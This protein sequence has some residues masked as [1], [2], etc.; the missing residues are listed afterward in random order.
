MMLLALAI[1][2]SV[3]V[4]V[5][6]SAWASGP[7]LTIGTYRAEVNRICTR[8]QRETIEL[9]TIARSLAGYRGGQVPKLRRAYSSLEELHPP[10]RFASL[11]GRAVAGLDAEVDMFASL[12]A[13]ARTGKLSATQFQRRRD[14]QDL[15]ARLGALWRALDARACSG[16]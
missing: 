16:H 12:A 4:L 6:T 5:A 8:Q 13:R 14:V 7:A 11:H 15:T 1:S 2:G 9:L 3:V 10:A